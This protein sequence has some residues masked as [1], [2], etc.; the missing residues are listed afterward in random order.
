MGYMRDLLGK[1]LD[2]FAVAP[3]RGLRIAEMVAAQ[4]VTVSSTLATITE[5][6]NFAASGSTGSTYG[7]PIH[8]PYNQTGKWRFLGFAPVQAAP[9]GTPIAYYHNGILGS[10]PATSGEQPAGRVEFMHNGSSVEII[11]GAGQNGQYRIMADGQWVMAAASSQL[12]PDGARHIIKCDFGSRAIRRV[13]V[14]FE[15]LRFGGINT[16]GIDNIWQASPPPTK[17]LLLGD[18]YFY[19]QG[20]QRFGSGMAA[21]LAAACGWRDVYNCGLRGSGYLNGASYSLPFGARVAPAL[22]AIG[23]PDV[24][25]ILGSLNDS[26]ANNA[27]WTPTAVGTA[28]AALYADL[29][30]ACPNT[31]VFV[32]GYQFLK[33]P[34]SAPQETL[35]KHAAIKAAALAAPN[36]IWIDNASTDDP[37]VTGVGNAG[38]RTVTDAVLNSTTTITSATA[39][40]TASDVGS[41]I[42]GTGIP[43]NTRIA[44][45]TNATTAVLSQAATATASGVSVTITNTKGS[46]TADIIVSPDGVHPTQEGHEIYGQRLGH[47]IRNW[48]LAQLRGLG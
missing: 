1:R 19:G 33:G 3:L 45:A 36:V 14:E 25:V 9:G 20:A 5:V 38:S 46:G 13:T 48:Y 23:T 27:A 2:S 29:A 40:F 24:I 21:S 32:S 16:G 43:A 10:A 18:S 8:Y 47:A 12:N 4:P 31:P 22:A 37:W 35:D 28:A 41:L 6:T 42:S 15:R 26:V 44:S 17:A 34:G 30:T 7:T 39:A 11:L